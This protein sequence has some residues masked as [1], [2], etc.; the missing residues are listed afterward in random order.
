MSLSLNKR[1]LQKCG[2]NLDNLNTQI[3]KLKDTDEERLK[4]EYKRLVDGLKEAQIARE[5]DLSLANPILPQDILDEAVPGNI[6]KA[7][8]FIIFMKRFLEYVKTRLRVAHKV[9]ET[10]PAFLKDLAAK[11]SIFYE[12]MK[13]FF[14]FIKMPIAIINRCVSNVNL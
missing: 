3:K 10:P 12:Q 7:E 11:V 8:H 13:D 14:L 6:R 5:T 4:N 2:E 9:Q 1:L